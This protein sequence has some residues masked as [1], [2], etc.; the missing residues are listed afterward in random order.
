MPAIPSIFRSPETLTK[1]GCALMGSGQRAKAIALVEAALAESDDPA[2]VSA[3]RVILSHHVPQ[4][5]GPMLADAARNSA[6]E[7]AIARA[8]P[9]G[10]TLLDIGA[11][12]GLLSLIAARAGAASVYACEADPALAATAAAIVARNGWAGTVRVIPKRSTELD[13]EIDL[14]GGA[15]VIVAEIFSNDLINEGALPSLEHAAAALGRPGARII[16]AAA[17]IEV[18]LAWLDMDDTALDDVQGF[19][20]TLFAR[21]ASPDLRVSVSSSKLS[22]RS[23]PKSLFRFDFQSGGPFPAGRAQVTLE[24]R[25]GAANGVVRWIRLEH[26]AQAEN[27]Q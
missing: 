27:E 14:G 5:H 8:L 18:A 20:L 17:S 19:A 16:P 22:L 23:D 11:G 4:W 26:N 10:G 21:H 7:Q 13:R 2:L 1:L 9:E 6:F 3:A 25:D 24:A 12:S 15:D